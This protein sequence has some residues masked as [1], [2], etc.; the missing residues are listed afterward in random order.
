MNLLFQRVLFLTGDDM[1]FNSVAFAIFLPIVF[2]IYWCLPKRCQW[3][4]LFAASYYFYMSWNA[5][6]VILILFTTVVSYLC[7]RLLE[8][9]QTM[10]AKK[11]CVGAALLASLSVLFVYKYF[12][13]FFA[14]LQAI[15]DAIAIP[16]APVTL[17][18]LLP[19]GISF[20]TFQTLSYVID[21]YHGKIAAEHH[22]GR[23]ATFVSFFPQ[24][25][26]GPIERTYNLLPQIKARHTFSYAQGSYGTKLMA[27]GF[28]KKV[29]IADTLAVYVDTVYADLALHQGFAL[30]VAILFFTL[31]IY[32]DFSGYS[33][34]A[35]GVAK[36]FGIDL[37]INFKS[38]YFSTSIR[39]F[40]GRWHISLSTWFRDYVYIPLGGNRCSR[41]KNTR[42][43]IITFLV[44]GLWHGAN[45]TFVV[46]GAVH[47]VAQV[48]EN[49]FAK[50]DTPA[51]RKTDKKTICW[52]V[53]C[54]AVFFFC[55][56]AWVVF[57]ADTISDA[58][59]LFTHCLVGITNPV[60][61]LMQGLSLLELWLPDLI[62]I[63]IPIGILMAYDYINLTKDPI[64]LLSRQKVF[65]RWPIYILLIVTVLLSP[66]ESSAFVYFQF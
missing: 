47:G 19:V 36:L 24:L 23:Y 50:A 30:V 17:Q 62:G 31:Q 5:A 33:D 65:V 14:G 58:I 32:C 54:A 1:L 56:L 43:L 3:V 29:V 22:F 35:I 55:N 40:W 34:I 25:V 12:S 61:Y 42:N 20:Y 8:Q 49:L 59:Y 15:C 38:P 52:W 6:Y 57:R 60:A 21:V 28:F 37:M 10:R 16:L 39:D 64:A 48:I 51:Q 27:W 11:V 13:F 7:A 45:I 53:K 2:A 44:S 9:M 4:V 63:A 46:W 26:A 66:S 18:L 41:L